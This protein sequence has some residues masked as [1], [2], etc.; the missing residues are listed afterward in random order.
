MYISK[1]SGEV[2]LI[3]LE[4]KWYHLGNCR[5]LNCSPNEKETSLKKNTHA[6]WIEL[7]ICGFSVSVHLEKLFSLP[8]A[9]QSWPGPGEWQKYCPAECEDHSFCREENLAQYIVVIG[10]KLIVQTRGIPRRYI[11]PQNLG[12]IQK[13][14][15]LEYFRLNREITHPSI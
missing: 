4:L 1:S 7:C 6:F 2:R 5:W 15:Y 8:A 14:P 11:F 9:S 10:S 3:L 13:H 12:A